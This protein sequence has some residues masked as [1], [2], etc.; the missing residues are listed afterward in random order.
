MDL[1]GS[2]AAGSR[3]DR[4]VV[5]RWIGA[6]AMAAVYLV[7]HEQLGT[8]HA[9]KV[10]GVPGHELRRRLLQEGRLQGKLRHPNVVA[11]SDLVDV[12]GHPGLVMEYV[13]G[14]TL[15]ELLEGGRLTQPQ[16]E[17]LATGLLAGVA[18]A[19]RHGLV[20]RDLKPGNILLAI[21]DGVP[22]PKIADFG[23][24]KALG[25]GTGEGLTRSG[26]MMGT[27]GYA[28]PE[29]TWDASQVDERADVFALGAILY[30]LATGQRAFPG[31]DIVEVFQA[32][33][34]GRFLPPGTWV[35]D[36]PERWERAILGAL[37]VQPDARFGTVDALQ[38]AWSPKGAHRSATWDTASLAGGHLPAYAGRR[39]GP[40]EAQDGGAAAD[41]GS[42][43]TFELDASSLSP[44]RGEPTPSAPGPGRWRGRHLA[45]AVALL[46]GAGA[47]GLWTTRAPVDPQPVAEAD[48]GAPPRVSEDPVVQRQFEQ[49]WHAL[50]DADFGEAER[51]MKLVTER[52]P[53]EP[54][55]YV[56]QNMALYHSGQLGGSISA[57]IAAGEAAGDREGSGPELARLLSA[58]F[59]RGLDEVQTSD[60]EAYL[61]RYPADP[62]APSVAVSFLAWFDLETARRIYE[63]SMATGSAP[64]LLSFV[65]ANLLLKRGH[66]EAAVEAARRGLV[67]APESPALLLVCGIALL[68]TGDYAEARV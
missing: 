38:A 22:V 48:A 1:A 46:V 61:R 29:Q 36:L 63:A 60:F 4:Y 31:N 62:L 34:E 44:P 9:L 50:L 67:E 2:L 52:E 51:R 10:V 25:P 8:L 17:D 24:A 41:V 45:L 68:D 30:E 32:I 7:R 12:D 27:P 40:V 20:H 16:V 33:R 35:P 5:L 14:P 37:V 13:D 3:V 26:V 66:W 57:I 53:S 55:P 64:P 15:E 11:V 47:V 18:A 65:Y 28:A 42:S 6:G 49:G 23:L 54:L 58:A 21:Q 19:H 59:L 43:E 56:V 39:G